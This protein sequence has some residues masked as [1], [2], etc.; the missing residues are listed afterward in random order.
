MTDPIYPWL[1]P[2]EVRRLAEGLM[3]P[4]RETTVTIEDA[5]FDQ[6]FV[7]YATDRPALPMTVAHPT[8]EPPVRQAPMRPPA[9]PPLESE[10]PGPTTA[11]GPFLDRITRF[12][13]WMRHQFAATGIFI[14]DRE[15]AVIF[16]E[17]SH[18]R[19]HFLARSLALASRRQG[20]SGGN[21]HVKIGAGAT[22]EVIP[23]DT[24]YGCLVL[25]AVV[26]ESLPPASVAAVMEALAQVASPA[27]SQ[28]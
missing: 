2:I 20:A 13:D 22:L 17:S 14:L 16:D 28:P 25:G 27:I 19:L 10:P 15:G 11:R 23:V 6:G 5:G 24:A 1:D 7:G 12:R 3:R 8:P 18:G 21:V 4:H 26:P 9:P